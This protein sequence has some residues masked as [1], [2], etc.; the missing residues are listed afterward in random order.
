MKVYGLILKV[1]L[2]KHG[3]NPEGKKG[4]IYLIAFDIWKMEED[5]FR[6]KS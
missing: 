3:K 6:E 5:I 2:K 1:W 4:K